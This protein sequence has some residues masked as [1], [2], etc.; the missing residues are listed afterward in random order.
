MSEIGFLF[1]GYA[2]VWVVLGVYFFSIG[3]RQAALRRDL[4]R[5]E[6]EIERGE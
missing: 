4:Q 3:R 5:L 6:R 2:V 1:A